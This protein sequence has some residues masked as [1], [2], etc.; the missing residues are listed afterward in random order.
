M[1]VGLGV[2]FDGLWHQTLNLTALTPH[3]FIAPAALNPAPASRR[4]PAIGRDQASLSQ[5]AGVFHYFGHAAIHVVP[6]FSLPSKCART[7]MPSCLQCLNVVQDLPLQSREV[8]VWS[9]SCSNL[10]CILFE[11]HWTESIYHVRWTVAPSACM[12]PRRWRS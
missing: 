12:R 2:V 5:E 3:L 4:H 6:V 9:A 11:F 7:P 10:L 1:D 8:R